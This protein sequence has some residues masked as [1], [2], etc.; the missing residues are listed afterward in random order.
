MADIVIRGLEMPAC[1]AECHLFFE[2][3]T[4]F[5]AFAAPA[6]LASCRL[7]ATPPEPWPMRYERRAEDCPLVAMPEG[8]GRLIDADAFLA[9]NAYFTDKDFVDVK[10]EDT[11]RDLVNRASTI[12]PADVEVAP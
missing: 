5:S 11:L 9:K 12:V 7:R 6:Y 3:W 1:C 2:K 8:H 10:Y 4:S